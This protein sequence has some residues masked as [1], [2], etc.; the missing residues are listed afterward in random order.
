M[1]IRCYVVCSRRDWSNFYVCRHHRRKN[2][3]NRRER[4]INKN[5]QS[6]I[7]HFHVY[8]RCAICVP[9][10]KLKIHVSWNIFW[11]FLVNA[12]CETVQKKFNSQ[13]RSLVQENHWAGKVYCRN[14]SNFSDMFKT[15]LLLSSWNCY[16][17]PAYM[18]HCEMSL[19][20]SQ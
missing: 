4:F 6:I 3:C 16:S 1:S 18:C 20:I 5:L 11:K 17:I 10:G 7:E 14:M 9:R 12:T 8:H 15:S 13:L 19:F 2:I